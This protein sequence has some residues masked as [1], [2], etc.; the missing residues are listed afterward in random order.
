[1]ILSFEDGETADIYNGINSK[2]A[3]KRLPSILLTKA[4]MKLDMI[5]RAI[6][7]DD[8]KTPPNNNLEKLKGNLAGKYSIRING[9]YRIIFEWSAQNA[10]QVKIVDYH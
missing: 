1:M 8:L 9:Q 6:K 4:Q 2:R 7:L 10:S 5:N 3:R